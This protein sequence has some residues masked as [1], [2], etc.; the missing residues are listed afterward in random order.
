MCYIVAHVENNVIPFL[1][2]LPQSHLLLLSLIHL[3]TWGYCLTLKGWV[4]DDI[5]GIAKFSD[6]FIQEK[7]A[8]GN[9]TKEYKVDTYDVQWPKDA[10]DEKGNLKIVKVP[11]L[12]KDPSIGFPNWIM[13]WWRLNLG[14]RFSKIGTNSKG[15]DVFGY[16][17]DARYHHAIN[18][19]AQLLNVILGYNLLNHLFGSQLAFWSILLFAVYPIGVQ[20]VA[21]ISG[22]N[23][24]LSLTFA[25][26]TFN[27]SIHIDN[28]YISIPL[29]VLSSAISCTFFLPGCFNFVILLLL[30]QY[31]EALFSFVVSLYF[32][33]KMGREVVSFRTK[34]F[35]DQNM[36]RSTTF[37]L[38]KIIVM[39]K[40]LWYYVRMV[41]FPK[42]LGLFHTWGYHYED[43][44]EHIDLE[45]VMGLL[46][47][48]GIVILGLSSPFCV[49][50]GLI[51][52]ISYLFIFSN[53]I[54]AQ[55]FV[56]ERYAY[57]PSFGVCLVVAYF[58]QDYPLILSF[59]VGIFMMRVWVHLPT[60]TNEVLFYES[61]CSNFPKSEVAM[62]NLGVSYLNHG[63]RYKA[64][65]QWTQASSQNKL[66]DVPWYNLYS[67]CKQNGDLTGA[68]KFLAMC[69][70]SKT[71]H[72][73][74]LWKKEMIDLDR[75]IAMNVP[76][77]E[78]TKRVNQAIKESKYAS[79]GIV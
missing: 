11:N 61:N 42:R 25:L 16:V 66:Y 29:V 53:F 20:A 36:G 70:D 31:N 47:F 22:I 41:L 40:T 74:D 13:R 43:P 17:Q 14:K 65:D 68:K 5:E 7:D 72:F 63:L 44:I 37:K 4:S 54:T 2:N 10:K 30:G 27:L 24:T 78:F 12:G 77:G 35:K 26:I 32:M 76:I 51:W 60:F 56:S 38:S 64:F 45:F 62:G 58:L 21:W 23:Y 67:I 79:T 34:A 8:Q 1:L 28:P 48:V 69:L 19:F 33:A 49:Q 9:V 52:F 55:Q 57:I 59:I 18:L 3:I 39:L 73:D 75:I 6:R 71:V 50:L 15:H 46:S